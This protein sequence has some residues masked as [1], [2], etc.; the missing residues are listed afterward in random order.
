M[1]TIV[2][3]GRLVDRLGARA[4]VLPGLLLLGLAT[5]FLTSIT[6]DWPLWWFQVV[7]VLRGLAFGLV[8]QPLT[9]AAMAEVQPVQMAQATTLNTVVRSVASSLGVAVLAA[10]FQTRSTVH[11]HQLATTNGLQALLRLHAGVLGLQDTAWFTLA[12][13]GI[14]IVATLFVREKKHSAADVAR[15][16]VST[17]GRTTY[18]QATV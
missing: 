4:V 12:F 2:V 1:V 18:H 3:G 7:L 14:A 5:W 9:V 17:A 16:A 11:Y 10:V 13:I 15:P 8:V 6:L